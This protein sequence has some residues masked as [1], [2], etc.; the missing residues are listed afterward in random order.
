MPSSSGPLFVS[1]SDAWNYRAQYWQLRT[2][3][4]SVNTPCT[5]L[6]SDGED[7]VGPRYYDPMTEDERSRIKV[8]LDR[9][10]GRTVIV[11]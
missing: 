10:A 5:T 4:G 9:A 1:S 6:S 3:D 2:K 8:Y 11:P 7:C